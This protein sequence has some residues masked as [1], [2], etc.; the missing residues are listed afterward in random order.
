MASIAKL[1]NGTRRLAF[2]D[3]AKKRFY[4][5]LGK[6]TARDAD[7]IRIKVENILNAKLLNLPLT[8]D[9]VHWLMNLSDKFHEKLAKTGLIEPRK[10]VT[11][12]KFINPYIDDKVDNTE[13][14]KANKRISAQ[15]LFH[16]FGEG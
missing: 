10:Q 8:P 9:L 13:S 5:R 2:T 16:F 14:T 12:S 3:E 1:K 15:M 6:V 7:S 4:I 11:L